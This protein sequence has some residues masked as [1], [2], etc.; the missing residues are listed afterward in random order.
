VILT[1]KYKQCPTT[2]DALVAALDKISDA[3][4]MVEFDSTKYCNYNYGE[5]HG[6][7]TV[8][9]SG[10]SNNVLGDFAPTTSCQKDD[11]QIKI[12]AGQNMDCQINLKLQELAASNSVVAVFLSDIYNNKKGQRNPEAST[13]LRF[14]GYYEFIESRYVTRSSREEINQEFHNPSDSEWKYLTF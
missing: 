3:E 12:G 2:L 14:L 9:G 8:F 13:T 4:D 7:I 11:P 6:A 1:H 5:Y 10:G